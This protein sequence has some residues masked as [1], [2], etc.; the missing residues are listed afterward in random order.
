MSALTAERVQQLLSTAT[1]GLWRH[2]WDPETE[3]WGVKVPETDKPL[4]T[5]EDLITLH[6]FG[7]TALIAHAPE[8]YAW[9]LEQH[10]RAEALAEAV[11]QVM[12]RVDLTP[13]TWVALELALRGVATVDEA[14]NG[15]K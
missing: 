1:P 4:L 5:D 9:A 14:L 3:A 13:G 2:T 10:A 11:R 6:P 7:D 12:A 15:G 8:V